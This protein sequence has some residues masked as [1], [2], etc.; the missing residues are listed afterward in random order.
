[1]N[2]MKSNW[3]KLAALSAAGHLLANGA[4]T[5]FLLLVSQANY[6]G[7]SALAQLHAL[8]PAS[9]NVTVHIDV[10]A[11]QTGVSRFIQLHDNWR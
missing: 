10:L 8:R 9:A 7:G 3:H 2:R 6:P 11:A 1:M 5:S 4:L